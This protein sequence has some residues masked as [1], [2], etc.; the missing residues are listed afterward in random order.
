MYHLVGMEKQLFAKAIHNGMTK[1]CM[2]APSEMTYQ[3]MKGG[4]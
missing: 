1:E 4:S 3:L 2:M